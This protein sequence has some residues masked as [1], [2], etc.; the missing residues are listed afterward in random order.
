MKVIISGGGTGGHVYP[1]LAI[2]NA[3]K[4]K[5]VEDIFFVGAQ[6]KLEMEK[7][8]KAGYNIEGLD[9]HGFHR[10]RRWRNI[11]LPFKLIKSLLKAK[12]I[13]DKFGPDIVVGVGGYASGPV[14]RIAQRMAIPTVIQEQNSYPGITNKL[15]AKKAKR[16]FVAYENM[17]R[18][19]DSMKL[20]LF[21][22]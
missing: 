10:T 22:I 2:A 11:F 3:L 15:L 18:F 16:I 20:S 14:L 12:K 8:P 17:D 21:S 7:V 19:F 4:E 13:I 5:G 1:A 6:G 9:I